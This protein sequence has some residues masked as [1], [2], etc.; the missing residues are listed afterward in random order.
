MNDDWKGIQ[1]YLAS[2]AYNADGKEP[3]HCAVFTN[4]HECIDP[5][6][7]S[8]STASL[9]DNQHFVAHFTEGGI[10]SDLPPS[11]TLPSAMGMSLAGVEKV[12]QGCC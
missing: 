2:K 12:I 9:W 7:H 11:E 10:G 1:T 8:V 5:W 4:I 3:R 6:C